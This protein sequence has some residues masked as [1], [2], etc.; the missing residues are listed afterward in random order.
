MLQSCHLTLALLVMQLWLEL[1]LSS[2]IPHSLWSSQPMK[3]DK[4]S[5]GTLTMVCQWYVIY[6]FIFLTFFKANAF[7]R[8]SLTWMRSL[9]WLWILQDYFYWVEVSITLNLILNELTIL[10]QFNTNSLGHDCS[11]RLWNFDNRTCV[12]E[13]TSHRKKFDESILDVSFHSS[14]SFFASAGADGLAKVFV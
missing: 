3:T 9:V 10:F 4:S 1:I 13:I 11:V 14:K 2:V 7:T 5:F 6:A 12:Q 8:W